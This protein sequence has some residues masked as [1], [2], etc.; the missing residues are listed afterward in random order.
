MGINNIDLPA[1]VVEQLFN[2][3]LID[4]EVAAEK[5]NPI[6]T[7]IKTETAS[8][9]DNDSVQEWKS[10]GNNNKKIL[11][12]LKSEDAVHLPDNQLTF[13][14]GILSACNLSLADVAIVNTINHPEVSYKELTTYFA[15]KVVLLFD[16]EPA[17]F[18]LPIN[19]PFYQIQ[20]F[21]G[22]SFLYSPSLN[23]LENDKIEKSKL[24]VCLKRL[25]NL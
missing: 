2:S 12:V 18:G 17:T 16:I 10:L 4:N 23:N 24:W 13:L 9:S 19:F 25:F 14:T 20:A 6:S 1:I 7:P 11:I 8:K 21:A 22:N 15:S 5:A 3:S